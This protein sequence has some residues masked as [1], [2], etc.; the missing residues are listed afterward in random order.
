MGTIYAAARG[1]AP[2]RG[3][4][5]GGVTEALLLTGFVLFA[6][7]FV[8]WKASQEEPGPK[9]LSSVFILPKEMLFCVVTNTF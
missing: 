1:W 9:Y 6:C 5:G 3:W 4:G 7:F 8:A 2:A